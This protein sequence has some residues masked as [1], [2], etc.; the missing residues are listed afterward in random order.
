MSENKY[1]NLSRFAVN[2][3]ERA[4]QGKLDPVIG[5]DEEIRRNGPMK[6]RQPAL[7]QGAKS[8]GLRKMRKAYVFSTRS[9]G[10]VFSRF[11]EKIALPL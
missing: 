1:E 8:G 10:S 4:A 3:N 9:A 6:P 7:R 2:L 5:R 11:A